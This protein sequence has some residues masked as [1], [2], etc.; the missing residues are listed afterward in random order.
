MYAC[1]KIVSDNSN[2]NKITRK[3]K[4]QILHEWEQSTKEF[5]HIIKGLTLEG[6]EISSYDTLSQNDPLKHLMVN[7]KIL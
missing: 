4:N 1:K 6:I 2:N 7:I 5:T 3:L